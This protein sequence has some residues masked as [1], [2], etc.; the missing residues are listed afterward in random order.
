MKKHQ[1]NI[2][3]TDKM[4]DDIDYLKTKFRLKSKNRAIEFAVNKVLKF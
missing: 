4:W 2:Y 3:I 1:R